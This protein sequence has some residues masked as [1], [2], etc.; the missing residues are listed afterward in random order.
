MGSVVRCSSTR[1]S[2]LDVTRRC[3]QNPLLLLVE[4]ALVHGQAMPHLPDFT[5]LH[6]E[7]KPAEPKVPLVE[8]ISSN[9]THT[10]FRI[11]E[12]HF[13]NKSQPGKFPSLRSPFPVFDLSRPDRQED[14]PIWNAGWWSPINDS[15]ARVKLKKRKSREKGERPELDYEDLRR[16]S[17]ADGKTGWVVAEGT[18]T[19]H[20]S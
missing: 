20:A 4:P 18:C 3:C 15:D 5:Q 2:V 17:L 7:T 14:D 10:A 13:K 16:I 12:K 8:Q 9:S 19:Q 6:L 11:C 1:N